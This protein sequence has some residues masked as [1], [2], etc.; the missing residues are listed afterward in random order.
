MAETPSSSVDGSL[1]ATDATLAA[2]SHSSVSVAVTDGPAD[3]EPSSI[4]SEPVPGVVSPTGTELTVEA[5]IATS[6]PAANYS[7]GLAP[8]VV[9]R[10]KVPTVELPLVPTPIQR[11]PRQSRS[12][13]YSGLLPVRA[14]SLADPGR[15]LTTALPVNPPLSVVSSA[16]RSPSLSSALSQDNAAAPWPGFWLQNP[17]PF[18]A[19]PSIKTDDVSVIT[20]LTTRHP[21]P[22]AGQVV[23]PVLDDTNPAA[24]SAFRQALRNY[25]LQQLPAPPGEE[26]DPEAAAA[27][28][29]EISHAI[30]WRRMR[31]RMLLQSRPVFSQLRALL[32]LEYLFAKPKSLIAT[33][34]RL[35]RRGWFELIPWYP[36]RDSPMFD[37]HPSSLGT[38]LVTT[39]LALAPPSEGHGIPDSPRAAVTTDTDPTAEAPS[40]LTEAPTSDQTPSGPPT[41]ATTPA[42]PILSCAP[43]AINPVAP[44]AQVSLGLDDPELGD[45]AGDLMGTT[46]PIVSTTLVASPTGTCPRAQYVLVVL[47]SDCLV[48]GYVAEGRDPPVAGTDGPQPWGVCEEAHVLPLD[49]VDLEP[50]FAGLRIY[51]GGEPALA[52][53]MPQGDECAAWLDAY[54]MAKSAHQIAEESRRVREARA[55]RQWK[56]PDLARTTENEKRFWRY[57]RS[58]SVSKQPRPVRTQLTPTKRTLLPTPSGTQPLAILRPPSQ[59]GARP[60]A[61]ASTSVAALAPSP[62]NLHCLSAL[63]ANMERAGLRKTSVGGLRQFWTGP[64]SNSSTRSAASGQG[65]MPAAPADTPQSLASA[66][67]AAAVAR[68][69]RSPRLMMTGLGLGLPAGNDALLLDPFALTPSQPSSPNP[70]PAAVDLVAGGVPPFPEWV[71]DDAVAVCMVCQRTAFTLLVR[72]HHCRQCGRVICYRCSVMATARHDRVCR[73]CTDCFR[74]NCVNTFDG[75]TQPGTAALGAIHDGPTA[76]VDND[77][78]ARHGGALVRGGYPYVPCCGL[79]NTR[80][81][82]GVL[83]LGAW[84]Q[85]NAST[86]NSTATSTLRG[87]PR[88]GPIA[89]A[90]RPV[91]NRSSSLGTLAER[92]FLAFTDP[93]FPPRSLT[94]DPD[95]YD[96]PSH[97]HH[98]SYHHRLLG[99]CRPPGERPLS[100]QGSTVGERPGSFDGADYARLTGRGI[101]AYA[102]ALSPSS[103]SPLGSGSPL[104][105]VTAS[106]DPSIGT[107]GPLSPSRGGFQYHQHHHGRAPSTTTVTPSSSVAYTM[108]HHHHHLPTPS[109]PRSPGQLATSGARP[110]MSPPSTHPHHRPHPAFHFQHHPHPASSA[111][112]L[113][114]TA[115]ATST[116]YATYNCYPSWAATPVFGSI[117]STLTAISDNHSTLTNAQASAPGS[118]Q[119]H[120][121]SPYVHPDPTF[122]VKRRPHVT[123]HLS[124][125]ALNFKPEIEGPSVVAAETVEAH[126]GVTAPEN[127]PTGPCQPADIMAPDTGESDIVPEPAIT[128]AVST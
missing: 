68:G 15:N 11:T 67:S 92:Q 43:I 94:D 91:R 18:A 96:Q 89:V 4:P 62:K 83:R 52:L 57:W 60:P 99:S 70:Q 82:P 111:V 27:S 110:S 115:T 78:E 86:I 42:L 56:F 64:P 119:R 9:E 58:S 100:Y 75:N 105:D 40:D 46:G 24:G 98:D 103:L 8:P 6:G 117:E 69:S 113:P 50:F 5:E 71:P 85:G 35:V 30:K 126:E 21:L 61:G 81:H 2:D 95:E 23:A 7:N 106:G 10:E 41:V 124:V 1:P 73:L 29:E 97:H 74:R 104:P 59:S 20:N 53:S 28:T 121:C 80:G 88:P 79:D 116:P 19:T 31:N 51:H 114:V 17:K 63:N 118:G 127:E 48:Y 128:E 66:L 87:G 37:T 54:V 125:T 14:P 65:G 120:L 38:P 39:S 93:A 123:A 45:S 47:M 108:H 72:K 34:R 122:L 26:T 25:P 36:D 44:S 3:E 49:E 13:L 102:R 112:A 101:Y 16:Q 55:L 109:L 107:S 77:E 32:E 76:P 84:P 90:G 12:S 33:G 22:D